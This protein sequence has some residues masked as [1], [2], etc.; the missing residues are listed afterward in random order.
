MSEDVTVWV[1]AI[2]DSRNLPGAIALIDYLLLY[3][4]FCFLSDLEEDVGEKIAQEIVK[5]QRTNL[6]IV[7]NLY[8]IE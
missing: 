7:G 1:A 4:Q 6:G 3:V 8:D 2:S 5:R